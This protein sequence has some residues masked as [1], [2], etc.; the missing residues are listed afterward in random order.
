MLTME[1]ANPEH[2]IDW[3]MEKMNADGALDTVEAMI[4]EEVCAT[5][6]G[7]THI[8]DISLTA[9]Q[10][11][12]AGLI[13]ISQVRTVYLPIL[14]HLTGTFLISDIT[15]HYSQPGHYDVTFR[16]DL[17]SRILHRPAYAA[18]HIFPVIEIVCADSPDLRTAQ[19]VVKSGMRQGLAEQLHIMAGDRSR[20]SL[21]EIDLVRY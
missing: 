8:D 6:T 17:D 2:G 15:A 16:C 5:A 10:M 18:L 12:Q 7:Y 3:F 4:G 21:D 20:T 13:H 11:D 14:E 1:Q 19:G 9:F